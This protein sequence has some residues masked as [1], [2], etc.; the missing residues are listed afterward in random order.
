MPDTYTTQ[1]TSRQSAV[2]ELRILSQS[3]TT[4]KVIVPMIVENRGN[5]E[6]GVKITIVHQRKSRRG[7]WENME[8]P[9]LTTLHAGEAAKMALDSGETLALHRELEQLYALQQGAGVPQGRRNLIV[10]PQ[11]QVVLTDPQRAEAIRSMIDCGY[12]QEIWDQLVAQNPDLTTR[13]S[14]ARIHTERASVLEEFRNSMAEE[15]RE[16]YWQD[17]FEQH[18]WIFGYGLN[19]QILRLVEG[20]PY[21]GG[22]RVEGAGDQRGD[23]LC[24]TEALIKFTVLVDIKKPQ[25]PIFGGRHYR[26]GA[27]SLH[28]ELTGGVSQLQA[29]CRT[30][31][32]DGSQEEQT[33]ERLLRE[34]TYTVEPDSI[35]V[36]GHSSQY[37]EDTEKRNTFEAFRQNLH[38]PQIITFDELYERA[39]FIVEQ[40]TSEVL[41][42]PE[43]T[44][45]EPPF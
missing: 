35:L 12:S 37:A 25:S 22:R 30:W 26:N 9:S 33:H 23:F 6:A 44:D 38:K 1:S 16:G 17:F 7:D 20:Q 2:V 13:L 31:D 43:E 27:W 45:G 19:Y 3:A 29:N 32:H 14:Y 34:R 4:R 21:Y 11:E 28:S 40:P 41:Q 5:P 8:S 42:D 10:A 15:K 24:R 18:T 36:I 39:K